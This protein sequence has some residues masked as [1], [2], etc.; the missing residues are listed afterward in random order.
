[1][2]QFIFDEYKFTSIH[3]PILT[4]ADKQG[5]SHF[6][7][8]AENK[9]NNG[10]VEL[11]FFADTYCEHSEIPTSN[12]LKTLDFIK[13][14]QRELIEAIYKYTKEELYPT[15][16]GYIGYDEI[17]FPNI[18]NSD[19]L[20]KAIG[21]NEIYIVRE[22]KKGFCYFL[23]NFDFSGDYEHGV[24]LVFHKTR[25]L[26]WEEDINYDKINADIEL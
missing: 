13:E 4:Q 15:H 22:Y 9:R 21:I 10:I 8:K 12:Q 3:L 26:G 20:R 11:A 14:N 7:E 25:V 19:D 6:G 1:M 24:I 18:N 5:N 16:I 17:S 2:G 23:M